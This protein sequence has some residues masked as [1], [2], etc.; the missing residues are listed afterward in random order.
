MTR[1]VT[2]QHLHER[3]YV[4]PPHHHRRR[5]RRDHLALRRKPG[6]TLKFEIRNTR[7][8]LFLLSRVFCLLVSTG[9]DFLGSKGLELPLPP[10]FTQE[11][12]STWA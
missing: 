2:K 3:G 1:Y 4:L 9:T 6:G 8:L 7:K 11:G 5:C 12:P 10:M